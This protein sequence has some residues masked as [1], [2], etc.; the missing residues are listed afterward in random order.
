[1]TT[2]NDCL[3]LVKTTFQQLSFQQRHSF[4]TDL[5]NCCDTQLLH[6]IQQFISPKLK[7][8]FLKYLPIEIALHVL[9]FI[10]DP[11][12][13]TRASH[14]SK[15]WHALLTDDSPWK[16]LCFKH[17]YYQQYYC[18]TLSSSYREFFRRKYNIDMAWNLGGGKMTHC[19][20]K[21]SQILVTTLKMDDTYIIVGYNN[22]CVD[23]YDAQNAAFIRTLEGHEGGVW[24]L[25]FMKI[26]EETVLVTGGC[27]RTVRV[28]NLSTGELLHILEGHVS[29]IRCL[30]LRKGPTATSTDDNNQ[31][32]IVVTG[33]RDTSLRIWNIDS[34]ELVHLCTGHQ[35]SVRCLA[36]HGD[37]VASGSYDT[38]A[39][40]WSLIT[41]DCVHE[42]VGHHSQ[43]YAI[44]F[45]GQRVI[46][47][48]LDSNIR[49][50]SPIDG[51]CLATL[52]GHTSV[53]NLL[54]LNY[55]TLV[56]GG[57]D[58]CIRIWN[59]STDSDNNNNNNNNNNNSNKYECQHRISAHDN[60]MTCF[61]VDDKRILSGGQDGRVK[62][63]DLKRGTL[64]RNFTEPG[65]TVWR[66]QTTETKAVVV[67]KREVEATAVA[68]LNDDEPLLE[69]IMPPCKVVI[70]LHNFDAENCSGEDT[71]ATL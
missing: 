4:L 21:E 53:V 11:R 13:L 71:R 48:S 31:P 33:S 45:D 44:E 12:T 63:W 19:E 6:Y 38:T 56:S 10:D 17:K 39:R 9:S 37:Y 42:L 2:V 54:H 47:G 36:I 68:A 3:S 70:E 41:G 30:A 15:Y 49:V 40:L 60:S 25:D 24:A 62:L 8:D 57:G 52:K 1:M 67:L 34:G 55:P 50:W 69:N 16:A 14:V 20:R 66:L 65:K 27:D 22:H 64:I 7:V 35:N 32:N 51:T 46:T 58:G 26:G 5:L 61:A 28:W 29:T 18:K 59:L 23:I 43:I